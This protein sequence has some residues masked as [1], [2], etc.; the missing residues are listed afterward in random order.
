[1]HLPARWSR[2][3]ATALATSSAAIGWMS[4]EASDFVAFRGIIR[5]GLD[6]FE[7]W[8]ARIIV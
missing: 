8:V 2:T 4:A 6:E 3:R 1:M 5:D 7:D